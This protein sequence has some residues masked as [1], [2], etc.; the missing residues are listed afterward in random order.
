LISS[1]SLA[2]ALS[3]RDED[4][5]AVAILDGLLSHADATSFRMEI[6]AL[7]D[8]IVSGEKIGI[9][10]LL[11][12]MRDQPH[13]EIGRL[14]TEMLDGIRVALEIH[15]SGVKP[16]KQ[17]RMEVRDTG[18]DTAIA[19]DVIRT[20]ADMGWIR[21]VVGPLFSSVFSAASARANSLRLPIISP[22]ATADH[23]AE[24]G[25]Y[26]FQANPDYSTRGSS[27]AR[28][29]VEQ[30]RMSSFAIL[31]SD[32]PVGRAHA[33]A[34]RN[35][36]ERL[37]ATVFSTVYFPPPAEDLREQFLKI[38][39]AIMAESTLIRKKDL[40][41]EA[42]LENIVM[43]GGDTLA[44]ADDS[45]GNEF[46]SVIRLFGPTG[47]SIAESLGLPISIY[48]T[49]ADETD[50]PLMALDGIYIA[51]G[52]PGQLDYVA[53]QLNYFNIKAQVIGNNEW[54]DHGR[55]RDNRVYID[56]CLFLSDFYSDESDST[57]RLL[58]ME[59]QQTYQKKLTKFTL[60]GFDTMNLILDEI[61]QGVRSRNDLAASL[62]K[63]S[64]FRGLHADI[65]FAG[66][67]VN[68]FLHVLQYSNG[69][70]RSMGSVEAPLR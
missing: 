47:Y 55:L 3:R 57:M 13:S 36:A 44:I 17:V 35:E 29:A 31:G 39:R 9:G 23:L 58:S 54:Y 32:D 33:E 43:A 56:G 66:S 46:V 16:G 25:P 51:L 61:G 4:S 67:R 10:V 11:P 12:L 19:S 28:Y 27:A 7:R 37:G 20:L 34:F 45:T 42:I 70:T 62:S 18:R 41:V 5:L 64:R 21:A 68:R 49:T 24:N 69:E 38:R 14:A 63:V 59:L 52:E 1:I 60:Y 50:I 8:E 53:P 2:K 40:Q 26:I 15:N 65:I 6:L 30:L 48:D 22:T